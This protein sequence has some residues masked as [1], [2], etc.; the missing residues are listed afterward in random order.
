MKKIPET[1]ELDQED[2]KEAIAFWLNSE[3]SDGEYDYDFEISFKTEVKSV[4]P[5]RGAPVGG[6]SDWNVTVVTATATKEDK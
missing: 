4:P 6:M 3:H 2:I 1:F 5:P